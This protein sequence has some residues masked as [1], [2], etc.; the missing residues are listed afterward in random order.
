MLFPKNPLSVLRDGRNGVLTAQ[1]EI[2]AQI[3][4]GTDASTLLDTGWILTAADRL[5][6]QLGQLIEARAT[7]R[8]IAQLA[9]RRWALRSATRTADRAAAQLALLAGS[10]MH[11]T[12][13]VAAANNAGTVVAEPLRAALDDLA[14]AG[15]ALADDLPALAAAHAASARRNAAK[16]RSTT[17]TTTDTLLADIIDTCADELHQVVD[18]KPQCKSVD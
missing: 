13:T 15:A 8:Q 14:T 4:P 12:R 5:Y 10:V 18:L 17:P 9:P 3:R 1:R 16:L 7:A 11:L 2:L 6:Q